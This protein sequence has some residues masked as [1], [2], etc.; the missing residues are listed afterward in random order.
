MG[1][2]LL[3]MFKDKGGKCSSELQAGCWHWW[4]FIHSANILKFVCSVSYME[5]LMVGAKV[6]KH[7]IV[8]SVRTPHRWQ[9]RNGSTLVYKMVC[10][11]EWA[12]LRND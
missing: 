4:G 3:A 9:Q 10:T 7:L 8:E 11:D 2:S 5:D 12:E 6:E 1:S